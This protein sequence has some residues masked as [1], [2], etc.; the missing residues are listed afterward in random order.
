MVLFYQPAC[1]LV[2]FIE[3]LVSSKDRIRLIA[4]AETRIQS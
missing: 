3:R 1:F 4:V 2:G